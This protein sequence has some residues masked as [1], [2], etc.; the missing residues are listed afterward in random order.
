MLEILH[1]LPFKNEFSLSGDRQ[2][3]LG[4]IKIQIET[5]CFLF[6]C[7][8]VKKF[9]FFIR[10]ASDLVCSSESKIF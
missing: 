3:G 2:E 5:S 9:I 1:P 4:G 8:N 10:V 7:L 6:T